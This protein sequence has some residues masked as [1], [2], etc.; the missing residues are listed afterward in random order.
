MIIFLKKLFF[1]Y[2]DVLVLGLCG[3]LWVFS[4]WHVGS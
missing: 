2:L 3:G 1:I 4:C